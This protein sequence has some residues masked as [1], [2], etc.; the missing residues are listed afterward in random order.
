MNQQGVIILPEYTTLPVSSILR[1]IP[2]YQDI[3]DEPIPLIIKIDWCFP[4]YFTPA[5]GILKDD[6]EFSQLISACR[7]VLD[8]R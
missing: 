6:Q 3:N 8:Q 2:I 4:N 7:V 1:M 5:P